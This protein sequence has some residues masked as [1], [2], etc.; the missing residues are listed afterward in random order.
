MLHSKNGLPLASALTARLLID[1]ANYEQA[2]QKDK[3]RD[4][5]IAGSAGRHYYAYTTDTLNHVLSLENKNPHYKG[6]KLE[7]KYSRPDTATILLT[8]I[9]QHKDSIYV[10]L[11]KTQQEISINLRPQT[12][13]V[14][15]TLT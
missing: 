13:K 9:N 10:V 14:L 15:N 5:E 7:L 8:G 1:S 4:Y 11:N 6:E 12:L 2:F 3:D